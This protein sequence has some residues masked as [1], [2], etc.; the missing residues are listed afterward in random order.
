M[1]PKFFME[2]KKQRDELEPLF[3][4]L[5]FAEGQARL[6]TIGNWN[7]TYCARNFSIWLVRSK[8]LYLGPAPVRIETQNKTGKELS[9]ELDDLEKMK[10]NGLEDIYH[11]FE[12]VRLSKELTD[13]FEPIRFKSSNVLNKFQ[14]TYGISGYLATQQNLKE[15]MD[16]ICDMMDRLGV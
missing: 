2:R 14:L 11:K 13:P 4:E 9:I 6:G 3:K 16:A 7:G 8:G 10:Q 1:V 12:K 5:G 15:L